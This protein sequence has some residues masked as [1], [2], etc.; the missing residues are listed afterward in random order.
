M[1]SAHLVSRKLFSAKGE[2]RTKEEVV[3]DGPRETGLDSKA[4]GEVW[5]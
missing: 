3:Q 1:G 5:R 2:K 4:P